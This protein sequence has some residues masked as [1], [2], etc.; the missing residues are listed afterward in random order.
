MYPAGN[1]Y[2]SSNNT[3]YLTSPLIQTEMQNYYNCSTPLGMILEDQDG[4]LIPSHNEKKVFG[5]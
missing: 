3:Q 1:P 2:K 4:T 5:N